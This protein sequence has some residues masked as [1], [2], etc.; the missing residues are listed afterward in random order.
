MPLSRWIVAA[1]L[2]SQGAAAAPPP[3]GNAPPIALRGAWV[4]AEDGRP[5]PPG[6][7]TRGLQPSG[8]IAR[9]GEL[10]SIGDQRSEFPGHVFRID[11]RT[12]RL[13]GKPLR[14]ELPD[15]AP[16]E[17]AEIAAYRAIPN[18][19]FEG[20]AVHPKD[21]ATLFAVTEDKIPWVAEVR[22]EGTGPGGA[23]A[24]APMRARIARLSR[25]LLPEDT[26]SWRN[27]PNFRMEGCAVSDD[28]ATMYLAFERAQDELPRIHRVPVADLRSGKPVRLELQ[29]VDFASVPRRADKPRARLNVNDI[30]F[31]RLGGRPALLA[32]ARDQERLLAIDLD[33]GKVARIVDLV[34]L[35]PAGGAIE[36]VSPEG[37]AFD[38]ERDRLWIINDPDSVERNYRARAEPAPTGLFAEYS[39]LLFELKLSEA[40]GEAPTAAPASHEAQR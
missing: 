5:V 15:A 27:D 21:P 16:G 35:D 11:P 29:P 8:L 22:L 3:D 18:S 32:V 9:W 37:L 36:W 4:A 31:V 26:P 24:P 34:L 13:V 33:A 14:L 7:F 10:W 30:Q 39:P 23:G 28:A 20:L 17:D 25:L 40:L 38:R 2:F 19:D 6:S 1:A 12:A